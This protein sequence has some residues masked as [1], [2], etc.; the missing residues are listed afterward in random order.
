LM[1]AYEM[2]YF[3]DE[4][5]SK[6]I[7]NAKAFA[8]A[9]KRCGM[10]VAGD[11]DVG[12]TQTHQVVVNVGYS[13]GTEIAR[14]LEDN[15]IIVNYQAA[16]HEEGFTAA[17]AIRLGVSE[18]TRFGMGEGDFETVAQL[19]ADVVNNDKS[20]KAEVKS[21]RGGFTDLNFCFASEE[22]DGIMEKL[23][24]LV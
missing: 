11:A 7:A 24:A 10:D 6:V 12:Y 17:G 13:R 8:A 21:F 20:V 23:H 5:Q 22:F 18:M 3:K 16:P 9:L 19:I 4:Y 15:N 14:K 1:A 2:N